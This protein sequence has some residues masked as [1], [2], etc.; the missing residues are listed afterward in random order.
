VEGKVEEWTL[1][2][3]DLPAP[4]MTP[5]PHIWWKEMDERSRR[6]SLTQIKDKEERH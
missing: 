3:F 5:L 1:I 2:R 4:D 6:E